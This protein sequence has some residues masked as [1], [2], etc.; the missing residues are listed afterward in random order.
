MKM[1][2]DENPL[3]PRASTC[4]NESQRDLLTREK[5]KWYSCLSKP[6]RSGN[7]NWTLLTAMILLLYI[8]L[9]TT[10]NRIFPPS[11][12]GGE[13][14]TSSLLRKEDLPFCKA[15]S[16]TRSPK[17]YSSRYSKPLRTTRSGTEGSGSKTTDRRCTPGHLRQSRLQHGMT[18]WN[19]GYSP[20][21]LWREYIYLIC[22]TSNSNALS[23]LSRRSGACT[24]GS[25][26]NGT[27][28]GWRGVYG[29]AGGLP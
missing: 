26:D 13:T 11:S 18:C 8:A 15:Q 20:F 3:L 16:P 2:A 10:L 22:S 9:W 19:V 14:S 12:G 27:A 17:A 25:C 6:P 21:P 7:F 28:F 24:L 23:G 29:D 4:S 1:E 5:S